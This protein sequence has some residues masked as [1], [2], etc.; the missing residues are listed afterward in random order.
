MKS[1]A[2]FTVP[3]PDIAFSEVDNSA[4]ILKLFSHE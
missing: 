1:I 3:E 4:V 2:V